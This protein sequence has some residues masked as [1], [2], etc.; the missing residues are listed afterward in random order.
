MM[1]DSKGRDYLVALRCR[2]TE[3][4]ALVVPKYACILGGMMSSS[5]VAH[6]SFDNLGMTRILCKNGDFGPQGFSANAYTRI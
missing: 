1:M 6:F 3:R 2:D 4:V 5:S